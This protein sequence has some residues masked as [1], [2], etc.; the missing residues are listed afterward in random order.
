MAQFSIT[1][2]PT[3][4]DHPN[5]S[6]IRKN[7]REEIRVYPGEFNGHSLIHVRVF[8]PGAG[9]EMRPMKAGVAFKPELAEEIIMAIGKAAGIEVTSPAE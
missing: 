9:G 6:T 3:S 2:D 5:A 1:S 4:T 7:A 8:A